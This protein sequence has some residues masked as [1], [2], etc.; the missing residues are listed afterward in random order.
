MANIYTQVDPNRNKKGFLGVGTPG[1][2]FGLRKVFDPA[3]YQ[4]DFDATFVTRD[5]FSRPGKFG[6]RPGVPS[7]AFISATG[8]RDPALLDLYNAINTQDAGL[9]AAFLLNEQDTRETRER[10]KA[11]RD[12]AI[13]TLTGSKSAIQELLANQQALGFRVVSPEEEQAQ[14][15]QIAQIAARGEGQAIQSAASRGVTQAGPTLQ[16]VA[17]IRAQVSADDVMLRS[18]IAG[19]NRT[20]RNQ[21]EIGLTMALADIDR[22]IADIQAGVD[23]QPSDYL[24]YAQ[25]G[26]GISQF[27]EQSALLEKQATTLT[28][29]DIM[30]LVMALPG[31]GIPEGIFDF[32]G[33][34]GEGK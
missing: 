27:N 31:T 22:E 10:D 19:Q 7:S 18:N 23:F 28:P 13:S 9:G 5:N 17:S 34:G 1:G 15:Q 2:F 6:S 33:G 21:F 3:G 16:N 26:V 20:A 25:L 12:E 4:E 29:S 32:F 14:S 8:G 24:P 11:A 30:R